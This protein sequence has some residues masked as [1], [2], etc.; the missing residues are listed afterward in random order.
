MSE[1]RQ[2]TDLPLLSHF[3]QF[4][5]DIRHTP[6]DDVPMLYTDNVVFKDPI[7]KVIGLAELRSYLE[8][9]NKNVIEGKFVYLDQLVGASSA[10]IKWDMHFRHPRL[11]ERPIT[12]RGMSHI[13]FTDRIHFHEDTYDLGSML[14]EHVPVIG[15]GVRFLKHRLAQAAGDRR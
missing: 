4:Y 2:V 7:H 1:A 11:G 6:L 5:Q 14:Y 13:Q 3:K 10:Y 8:R 15:A 12:V 9:M